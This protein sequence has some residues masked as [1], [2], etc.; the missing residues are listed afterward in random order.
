MRAR[1]NSGR[2]CP[3]DAD[4]QELKIDQIT[5]NDVGNPITPKRPID[6]ITLEYL[7]VVVASR[8]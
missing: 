3:R 1:R 4:T 2:A 7:A 6:Q 8:R 5:M